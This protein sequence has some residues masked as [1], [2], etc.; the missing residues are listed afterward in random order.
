MLFFC[1]DVVSSRFFS[2]L[3]LEPGVFFFTHS[4]KMP[5][6]HRGEPISLGEEYCCSN[7]RCC[8]TWSG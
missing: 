7:K 4:E 3:L 1:L 6:Q 8:G 2:I 5:A